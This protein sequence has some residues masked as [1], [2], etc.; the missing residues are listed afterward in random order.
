M[1]KM[2]SRRSFLKAAGVAATAAALTACGGSSSTAAGGDA[3]VIT[4]G[5]MGPLTGGAAVY[6]NAV[7]NGAMLYIDQVNAAGGING[8]QIKAIKMD[9]KGDATEAVNVYTKMLDEGITGLIGDVTT[10]PTLAVVAESQEANMP[11]VTGS[12]TAEAVTYDAETDTVFS[13]VFRTTFTDPYQGQRM[14]DF[15]WEVMGKKT[16]AVLYASGNDYAE[17]LYKNFVDQFTANGGTVVAEEAYVEGDADFNAQLT[18]IK[19]KNPEVVFLPNY[20]QD[21]GMIL[22]QAR[23]L[24]ID[25][26]FIGGDGWDGIVT[27]SERYA[28]AAELAGCYFCANYAPGADAEFESSYEKAYGEAYPNGFAPLGYDAAVAL[29]YGIEKA[30]AAGLEAGS[31]EYKQAVIDGIKNGEIK[32]VTGTFTFDEHNNPV[33]SIYIQ[34]FD[35]E[36]WPVLDREF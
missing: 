15:A 23:G 14:A 18:N 2:I 20:Y 32:G 11:M 13:N 5:V 1:K 19:G 24:G 34:S 27:T 12:A 35:A 7:V 31:D 16:A 21:N 33:K 10:G 26:P 6:G 30:E 4:I 3:A 17:G 8:K 25:V 36:G 28:E 9:E 29:L 22:G